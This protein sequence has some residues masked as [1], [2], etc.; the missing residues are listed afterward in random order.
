MFPIHLNLGF[1]IFYYYEGFY[2][3]VAILAASLCAYRLQKRAGLDADLFLE[4]LPWILLGAFLGARIS[5]FLFWESATLANDPAAF[6]R[7]WE[8]GMSITGGLAGGVLGAWLRLRQVDFWRYAAV[9]SPAVLL[10]QAIGRIGCFLNGDA[11]GIPTELPWGVSLPRF[12]TFLPGFATDHQVSSDAW[13]WSVAQGFTD[14]GSLRTVPLHPT[15]L[16]EAFGDLALAGLVLMLTGRKGLGPGV[17]WFYLGGYSIL[18][19]G[20]EFL[21]GDRDV[22]IWA[23]MTALQLGLLTFALGSLALYGHAARR[24][25][26]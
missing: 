14:P 15:Q 2:F 1:R 11:W 7:F 17:T 19:F 4:S 25:A 22:T 6:F 23:G 9:T 26:H 8:G 18:R 5:H 3:F 10:G 13:L 21:H 24:P 12:G 20:L 16:Y